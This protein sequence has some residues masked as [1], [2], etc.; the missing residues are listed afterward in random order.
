MA[1]PSELVQ[2]AV[3]IK[4]LFDN[5]NARLDQAVLAE[6]IEP[7]VSLVSRHRGVPVTLSDNRVG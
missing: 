3:S 7:P 1:M 6:L 4:A 2:P 5:G